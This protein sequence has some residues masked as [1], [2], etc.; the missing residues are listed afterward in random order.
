M[1]E[2]Y[3]YRKLINFDEIL[4][5]LAKR[6]P[7]GIIDL[8][9]SWQRY[10]LSAILSENA[11]DE[12]VVVIMENIEN[13]IAEA[14]KKPAPKKPV[15][16][17]PAPKK[18]A[19]K[20]PAAKKPAAKK[21]ADK[22]PPT[23]S[24]E[25]D[26]YPAVSKNSGKVVYFSSKE[27]RSNAIKAGTHTAY[28][29]KKAPKKPADKAGGGAASSL[30]AKIAGGVQKDVKK[31][32][33]AEKEK[34]KKAAKK[35]AQAQYVEPVLV[36][37]VPIKRPARPKKDKS[38]AKINKEPFERP[39][40]VSDAAF[41]RQIDDSKQFK[42]TTIPNPPKLNI[43][44]FPKKYAQLIERAFKI[45]KYDEHKPPLSFLYGSGGAGQISAQVAE[46]L[47][48]AFAK[49][50]N[51]EDRI[52]LRDSMLEWV[53][54]VPKGEKVILDKSWINASWL[55]AESLHA[56]LKFKHPKGYDVIQVAWDTAEDVQALGLRDYAKNKGFSTDVYFRIKDTKTG[57]EYLLEDSLKKDEK[58]FLMNG[59]VYE[60][61]NFA[62]AKLDPKV[63]ETFKQL[64]FVYNHSDDKK[65][66]D[67]AYKEIKRIQFAAAKKVPKEMNPDT[68]KEEQYESGMELGK[69]SE[70]YV[71]FNK[72]KRLPPKINDKAMMRAFGS[73]KSDIE[74]TKNALKALTAGKFGTPEYLA[75]LK[76][77][78][79]KSGQRY[80]LKAS[81][82]MARYFA[83][84]GNGNVQLALDEHINIVKDFQ[85]NFIEGLAADPDF[86]NELMSKIDESFPLRALFD[87]E[88]QADIDSL[89]VFREALV[90]MFKTD[91]YDDLKSHLMVRKNRRGEYELVYVESNNTE[92]IP[93]SSISAR[94]RGVGYD[95]A[96][97]LEM[98]LHPMFAKRIAKANA[99]LGIRTPGIDKM[100]GVTK[101]KTGN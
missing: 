94:P 35:K 69:L 20:K 86:R 9:Q 90:N 96:P 87:G 101:K 1:Y 49:M 27:S 60:V 37:A 66:K 13:M 65:E 50:K 11:S 18:P 64:Q 29:A 73:K 78:T 21:P 30:A 62:V 52:K 31:K 57:K 70:K 2:H 43:P 84:L 58:V 15:A 16:K 85:K 79:G 45:Q 55:Q 28:S 88:E 41:K 42:K 53:A 17:K 98:Y 75:A 24:S 38:L 36:S 44:G 95:Q 47:M 19:A 39:I 71:V 81:V 12:D 83:A 91:N 72:G 56:R 97:A 46:V 8:S 48:M 23:P 68:F 7:S 10:E 89:P 14:P 77:L 80:T 40:R 33:K 76:K 92:A 63:Y 25:E 6:V 22:K 100:L 59:A 99:E 4:R 54:N 5:E 82:F 51:P 26:K 61:V 74:F 93:I 32:E 67:R 3:R 34:A